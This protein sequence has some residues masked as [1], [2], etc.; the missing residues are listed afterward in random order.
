MAARRRNRKLRTDAMRISATGGRRFPYP[1]QRVMAAVGKVIPACGFAIDPE[2]DGERPPKPDSSQRDKV[3]E[4]IT[5]YVKA[6]GKAERE[7]M[8]H[9]ELTGILPEPKA[10]S[11]W[12]NLVNISTVIAAVLEELT[13]RERR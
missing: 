11:E 8:V 2:S 10:Q 9:A 1:H 3:W 13:S 7:V 12:R 4:E 5:V 6:I